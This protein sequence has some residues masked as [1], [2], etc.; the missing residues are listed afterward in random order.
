MDRRGGGGALVAVAWLSLDPPAADQALRIS[1]LLPPE[2]YEYNFVSLG[3]FVAI[4]ALSPDGTRLV[5]GARS[6]MEKRPS[7]GSARWIR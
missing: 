2:G 1:S 5:F 3:S 6:R 4:P 7:S